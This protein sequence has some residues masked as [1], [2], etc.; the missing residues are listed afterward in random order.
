MHKKALPIVAACLIIV[1]AASSVT[2]YFLCPQNLKYTRYIDRS[3]SSPKE[4]TALTTAES[5]NYSQI[6][7]QGRFQESSNPETYSDYVYANF[8]DS[9][10]LDY[11]D[12]RYD[13]Q[14][15]QIRLQSP[16][17]VTFT[18]QANA[19]QFSEFQ[20]YNS[21][22]PDGV[23]WHNITIV[24][25]TPSGLTTY[26]SG[27]MQFFYKNQSNYQLTQWGY[28]FNFT[29]CC[30]VEMKLRYSEYYAPVAAFISEVYQIVVLDQDLTPVL[31]GVECQ[32][33]IA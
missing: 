7:S 2:W 29:N 10:V 19:T 12:V 14:E 16:K 26:N 5:I 32:N 30:V 23:S 4:E 22:A 9:D 33:I 24:K 15:R 28:N 3:F 31:V 11:Y 18:Y 25:C 27:N 21:P 6:I 8:I 1:I 17:G 20:I 13:V